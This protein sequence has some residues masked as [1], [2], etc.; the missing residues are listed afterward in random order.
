MH[1]RDVDREDADYLADY[2]GFNLPLTEYVRRVKAFVREHINT[3]D[4]GK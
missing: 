1:M 3:S 4:K 2:R